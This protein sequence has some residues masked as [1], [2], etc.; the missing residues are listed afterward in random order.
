[1]CFKLGIAAGFWLAIAAHA[2]NISG[3][4]NNVVDGDTLVL[5]ADD[6]RTLRIRLA[7]IDSPEKRQDFGQKAKAS[8]AGLANGQPAL[9]ACY[10]QDR[11]QNH[12]CVVKVNGADV[13]LAQV[14]AGMAWWYRQFISEQTAEQRADYEHAERDARAGRIGLWARPNP[15]APW[16][17]RKGQRLE[18]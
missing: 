9:A 3:R 4:V 17:W 5:S 6:G 13:G 14:H 1:M 15:T 18:E 16:D 2:E 11:Y 10:K 12:V 8:L 7:G